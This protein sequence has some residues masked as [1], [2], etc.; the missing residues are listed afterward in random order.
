VYAALLQEP[1]GAATL[2]ART[3][4]NPAA[5]LDPVRGLVRALDPGLPVF[6][7]RTM[8]EYLGFALL[9]VRL[10][11]T[12]LGVFGGI[13]L[14]LATVGIY[15]VTAYS[16]SRRTR[17][18]G[19]RM[20][21]GARPRDVLAL[22]VRQGMTP[23]LIGLAAGVLIALAVTRLLRSL[24]YGVSPTDA[25]TFVATALLLTGAALAACYVPARRASHVDPMTALRYE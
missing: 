13:G 17:E 16:V 1:G 9:P 11:G 14:L 23:A 5:S 12:L 15:G 3:A 7:A 8:R 21:L 22:V 10:A 6:E 25:L 4:G 18:V 24:L 19:V 20:A 2:V